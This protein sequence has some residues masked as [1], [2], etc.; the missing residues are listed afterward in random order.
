MKSIL[1]II[2][3]ITLN[4]SWGIGLENFEKLKHSYRKTLAFIQNT[5]SHIS[6]IFLMEKAFIE[7]WKN[8]FIRVF[9]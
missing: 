4:K 9:L 2:K 3:N 6:H 7:I 1:Q 8:N 5:F